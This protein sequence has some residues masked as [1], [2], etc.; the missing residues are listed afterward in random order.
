M[1]HH[2]IWVFAVCQSTHLQVS[3]FKC[4]GKTNLCPRLCM[5]L[6]VDGTLVH[7]KHKFPIFKGQME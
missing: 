5:T 4:G 7:T 3:N 2:V 6:A 1:L